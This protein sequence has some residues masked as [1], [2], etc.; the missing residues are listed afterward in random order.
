MALGYLCV[1]IRGDAW[2]YAFPMME[3]YNTWYSQ[4]VDS[5]S[6]TYIGGFNKFRHYSEAFTS[7]NHDVVTPNHDTPY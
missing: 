5:T 3:S 4:A 1:A 7:A 6:Q 2:L